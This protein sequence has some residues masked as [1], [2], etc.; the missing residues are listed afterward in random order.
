MLVCLSLCLPSASVFSGEAKLHRIRAACSLREGGKVRLVFYRMHLEGST[1]LGK[2]KTFLLLL[3][4]NSDLTIALLIHRQLC[5]MR[6][7]LRNAHS[8]LGQVH[9][10]QEWDYLFP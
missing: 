8:L 2:P 4:F 5:F 7:V 6:T 3:L 1:V 9:G 10:P